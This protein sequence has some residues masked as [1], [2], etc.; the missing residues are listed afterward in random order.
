[1]LHLTVHKKGLKMDG[2][3]SLNTS[4]FD[5]PFCMKM[6]NNKKMICHNCYARGIEMTYKN[7]NKHL[8]HNTVELSKPLAKESLDDV[9]GQIKSSNRKYIRFHSF[10]ELI[11]H[12]HLVNFYDISD[13]CYNH[14]FGLWTKR[15]DMIKGIKKPGNLSLIYSNPVIDKEITWVPDGFN[16]VFNVVSYDYCIEHKIIPNC[17][18][19][20]MTCLRCYQPDKKFVVNELVKHDQT[21]IRKGKIEPL[22]RIL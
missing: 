9:T 15:K 17:T 14:V 2:F 18:G 22:E 21:K 10:G 11:N 20:C 16:G 6:C 12:D 4:V 8:K 5:N 19:K 1:M 3:I 13:D 7:L